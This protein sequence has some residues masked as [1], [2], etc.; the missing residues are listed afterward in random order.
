[1]VISINYGLKVIVTFLTVVDPVGLVPLVVGM[2]GHYPKAERAVIIT[3]ATL[4]AAVVIAVFGIFGR[5]IFESLGISIY[6]FNIAGGVLLFLVAIDM[7]FGR[8]SGTRDTPVEQEEAQTRE[9]ISVFPLA[10]PLIAGPGT[11]ATVIL[12]TSSAGTNALQLSIVGIAAIITLLLAWTAMRLSM[13][14]ERGIGTTGIL[15]VS[16]ILGM[17]LGALAVQFV[18]NGVSE[19]ISLLRK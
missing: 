4:I 19:Y 11:I 12:L 5:L 10:I 9:D 13:Y 17:L 6:A 2:L 3:N 16:R 14:I 15:V 8:A 1:M 7:L 18:L